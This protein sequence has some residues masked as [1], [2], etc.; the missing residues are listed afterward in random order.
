MEDYA[1]TLLL[2][3]RIL[4]IMRK[5]NCSYLSSRGFKYPQQTMDV[6]WEIHSLFHHA[7]L[8]PDSCTQ[9]HQPGKTPCFV[10]AFLPARRKEQSSAQFMVLSIS[11]PSNQILSQI[12]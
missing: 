8:S 3:A 7:Q 9:S 6:P 1:G 4:F 12:F 11:F 10:W 2:N 5:H